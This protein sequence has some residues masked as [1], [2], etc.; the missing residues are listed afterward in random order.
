MIHHLKGR[1]TEKSLTHAV[2]ECN[3]VG[4][5]L[6]ISVNTASRLPADEA[7]ALYVH[8]VIREDAFELFG[9][10]DR[11]EREAFRKLIGV[12]GVGANTARMI[13]SSLTPD[14]LASVVMN[15]DVSI[16]KNVKGI[17]A[18]T[19]QRILVDLQGKFTIGEGG[20]EKIIQSGNTSLNEA[21]TALSSLGFDRTKAHKTLDRILKTEGPE[22]SVE[23]LIKQA[24][25]QL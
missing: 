4:Y 9:F 17:G 2:I 22:I 18:K 12:S 15:N 7:C 6:H 16:L 25:R 8:E 20:A 14:E 5:L 19:A 10:V 21:L 24:L 3:G 11:E 13:L 23:E 1:L